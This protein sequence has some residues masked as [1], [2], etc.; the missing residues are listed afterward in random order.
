MLP[1]LLSRPTWSVKIDVPSSPALNG[2]ALVAQAWWFQN[3]ALTPFSLTN[4]LL[5]GFG[6]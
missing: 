3:V 5:L 4:G 6:S 2:L 1:S